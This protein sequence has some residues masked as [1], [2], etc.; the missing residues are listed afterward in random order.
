LCEHED[1]LVLLAAQETELEQ[2]RAAPEAAAAVVVEAA[3][4]YD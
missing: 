2:L 3:T 4:T 1:L